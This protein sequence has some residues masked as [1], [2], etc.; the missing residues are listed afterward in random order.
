M[1]A[2]RLRRERVCVRALRQR[3]RWPH[4]AVECCC[5]PQRRP[6]S[7][8]RRAP[9]PSP[10]AHARPVAGQGQ[11]AQ[12]RTPSRSLRASGLLRLG[13]RALTVTG[14]THRSKQMAHLSVSSSSRLSGA[15][16]A[17][18]LPLSSPGAGGWVRVRGVWGGDA[19]GEQACAGG[20]CSGCWWIHSPA[21]CTQHAGSAA[22]TTR[23]SAVPAETLAFRSA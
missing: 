5:R 18:S 11:P 3:A 6:G 9:G 19:C 17:P 7:A 8:A 4:A 23:H 12:G 10:R 16:L 14:R 20:G 22:S 2:R 1:L 13:G 15:S 21:A